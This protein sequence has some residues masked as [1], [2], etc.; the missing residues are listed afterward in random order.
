MKYLFLSILMIGVGIGVVGCEDDDKDDPPE[1]EVVEEQVNNNDSDVLQCD[2]EFNGKII[3]WTGTEDLDVY[4]WSIQADDGRYY[5]PQDPLP[6][7]FKEIGLNV[8]VCGNE[9]DGAGFYGTTIKIV[10]IRKR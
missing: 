5:D 7:D 2:Y 8:W 1:E 9:G 3:Y 6:D 4:A 10:E